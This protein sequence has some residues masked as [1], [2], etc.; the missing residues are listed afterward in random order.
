MRLALLAPAVLVLGCL[1]TAPTSGESTSDKPVSAASSA[2]GLSEV[3]VYEAGPVPESDLS[4]LDP[5]DFGGTL[6]DQDVEWNGRIDHFQDGIIAGVF[7]ATRGRFS[8]LYPGA[9]HQTVHFGSATVT[10]QYGSHDLHVGDSFL[11]TSGT[12]V[13]WEVKGPQVQL[14][15]MGDFTT[16]HSPGPLVIYRMGSLTPESELVSLGTPADFNATVIEGDPEFTG[17]IDYADAVSLAGI[18]QQTPGAVQINPVAVTEHGTILRH[19]V[20]LTDIHGVEHL[21][22]PG[23][24]YFILQGGDLGQA[25]GNPLVQLSYFATTRP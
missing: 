14:S 2:L 17:R 4:P 19:H 13:V 1:S 24:S 12:S 7:Q 6:I 18:F 3:I 20:T 10:D 21:L 16:A 5:A 23:D 11:V 9:V 22:G 15:F 25:A 8:V